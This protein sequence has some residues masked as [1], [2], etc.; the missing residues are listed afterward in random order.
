MRNANGSSLTSRIART[1]I[2][3]INRE[4]VS[5]TIISPRPYANA[6]LAKPWRLF[7]RFGLG[8]ELMVCLHPDAGRL[9]RIYRLDFALGMKAEVIASSAP[10]NELERL[11]AFEHHDPHSILGAHLDGKYLVVRAFRPDASHIELLVPGDAPRPMR[12]RDPAGLFEAM[13]E[14]RVSI[15]PY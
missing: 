5:T 13:V 15:F 7:D 9:R 14:G 10:D 11:L 1:A 12:L 3:P 4:L 8:V 6:T 2:A